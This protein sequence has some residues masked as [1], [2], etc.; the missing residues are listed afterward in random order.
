MTPQEKVS[1]YQDGYLILRDIV[2]KHLVLKAAQ[3]LYQDLSQ[4][5]QHA[6]GLARRLL[7][8][9]AI[10]TKELNSS[11]LDGVKPALRTGVHPAIRDLASPEGDL[12]QSIHE[13]IGHPTQKPR[14]AQIATIFPHLSSSN[15]NESGYPNSMVPFFGWHGHLDGLWNGSTPIHQRLDRPMN[16]AEIAAWDQKRG[17]NGVLKSFPQFNS[18]VSN[19]TAL[20]GIPLSDQSEPGN[21]NLGLLRGAHHHIATFFSQQRESG[22]PLGPDGPNWDRIDTEAPNGCGLRHYPDYVRSQYREDAAFTADG[23]MWPKPDLI[24]VRPG[25][26]VLALHA[27]P[28]CSTRN[29][30]EVPR[31]MV[32]FRLLSQNRPD[33]NRFNYP[34]ALCDCWL[35]WEGMQSTVAEQRALDLN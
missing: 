6:T 26:A 2:P 9:E 24:R 25:D 17:R 29:E 27:V 3:V 31:L 35:E 23:K 28:H 15:V 4:A 21:G 10:D 14:G 18:N 22:G 5:W 7:D 13:A 30:V 19:F 1:F 32:Y 11:W 34:D 20:L 16:A 12:M 8:N 33:G